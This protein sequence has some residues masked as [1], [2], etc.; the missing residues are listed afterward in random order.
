MRRNAQDWLSSTSSFSTLMTLW[1]ARIRFSSLATSLCEVSSN[2]HSFT[3]WMIAC[4]AIPVDHFHWHHHY[5]H[6]VKTYLVPHFYLWVA[7]IKSNPR[8]A[9]DGDF[10][11]KWGRGHLPPFIS[12]FKP[13]CQVIISHNKKIS[14]SAS[15][16]ST[17]TLPVHGRSNHSLSI[18][19]LNTNHMFSQNSQY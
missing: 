10:S 19:K 18:L 7:I 16:W 12:K 2:V 11:R 3:A 15:Y 14:R 9:A 13:G 1:R 5:H 6:L 8:L 4:L 17:I